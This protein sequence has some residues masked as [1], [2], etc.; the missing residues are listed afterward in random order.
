MQ[1]GWMAGLRSASPTG[2]SRCSRCASRRRESR[3]A[4]CAARLCARHRASALREFRI[5]GSRA[6]QCC[7]TICAVISA[8]SNPSACG[9]GGASIYLPKLLRP[10][11]ASLLALLWAV[12]ARSTSTFRRRR[13]RPH[14][15]R[16][17]MAQP[18]AF[19]CRRGFRVIVARRAMRL[20]MLER[21]EEEL[22]TGCASRRPPPMR[23]CQSLSRCSAAAMTSSRK[24]LCALG[25]RS[26]EVADAGAGERTVWRRAAPFARV[27]AS[28]AR[29]ARR[30]RKQSHRRTQPFARHSQIW[31]PAD[32]KQ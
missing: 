10:E 4:G 30:A 20:D 5:A 13:S 12:L 25:W 9:S 18:Y 8:R 6:G 31:R 14:L 15:V 28:T 17:S 22:E 2:C 1:R 26:V 32:S 19:S 16:R 27:S 21:L 7:R 23:C 24:S 3:N 29:E 11:A